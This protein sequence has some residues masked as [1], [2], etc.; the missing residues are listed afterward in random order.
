[1]TVGYRETQ[2]D[3]IHSLTNA[4]PISLALNLKG[5]QTAFFPG[6]TFAISAFPENAVK[7]PDLALSIARRI[8]LVVPRRRLPEVKYLSR[9]TMIHRHRE[10]Q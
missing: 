9:P 5:Q 2:K 6:A 1:M 3:K 10:V 8:S 4:E 7:S